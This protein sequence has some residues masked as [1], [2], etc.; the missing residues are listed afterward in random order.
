MLVSLILAP[1]QQKVVDVLSTRQTVSSRFWW[2]STARSVSL[3]GDW[4]FPPFSGNMPGIHEALAQSPAAP[5][6]CMLT[7]HTQ[8]CKKR[9]TEPGQ[10]RHMAFNPSTREAKAGRSLEFKTSLVYRVSSKTARTTQRNPVSK[11]KQ[12]KGTKNNPLP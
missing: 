10:W 11:N 6:A 7:T 1:G 8:P 5:H 4:G 2:R 9:Q 3:R 12:K